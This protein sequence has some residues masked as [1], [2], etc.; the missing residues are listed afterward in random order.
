MRRAICIGVFVLAAVAWGHAGQDTRG[1]DQPRKL[2][3]TYCISCHSTRMHLGGLALDTLA[4]D[5]V[6]ENADVWEKAIRKLRGRQMPPPGSRQPDQRDIDAFVE[7]FVQAV[8]RVFP[9]ALLQWEDFAKNNARRLLERYRDRLC[10]FNDDIQGTGAVNLAAVLAATRATRV[11][12][13][14]HRIVIFGMGTAGAGIADQ[15][16]AAMVTEGVPQ[17]EARRQFWAVDRQGLLTKDM[18][19][20]S[21]L[22]RRYARDPAE[23]AGWHRDGIGRRIA[24]PAG[25]QH[26][27]F[28]ML[29]LVGHGL[30][31]LQAADYSLRSFRV[32]PSVMRRAD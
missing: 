5:A 23:V 31:P 32:K 10:S 15:L 27:R 11:P 22:Q 4:L 14:G 26:Q 9:G 6:H 30:L 2:L 19:A 28:R 21:D 1:A 3:D 12:L 7:A 24:P 17:A 18:A 13:A 29:R 20:L 16:T 8:M 25:V